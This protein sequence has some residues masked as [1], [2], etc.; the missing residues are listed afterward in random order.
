MHLK[1]IINGS[2][3]Y[4]KEPSMLL[5]TSGIRL[6]TQNCPDG[7]IL[8]R[9]LNKPLSKAIVI[10]KLD[11]K[12]N[13][14][15]VREFIFAARKHFPPGERPRIIIYTDSY[16]EELEKLGWTGL[17]CEILEYG[18]IILKCGRCEK[19]DKSYFNPILGVNLPGKFQEVHQYIG[20][21]YE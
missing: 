18:N 19:R 5:I 7:E 4:Y 20:F 3:Q 14:I 12:I 10:Y 6:D 17:Y 1:Q 16:L 9:F 15:E 2:R 21:Q 11:P 13:T 8:K